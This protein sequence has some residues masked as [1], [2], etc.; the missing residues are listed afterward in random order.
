MSAGT[1]RPLAVT[2]F[3]A[4]GMADLVFINL[5]LAPRLLRGDSVRIDV[6]VGGSPLSAPPPS[7]SPT[8]SPPRAPA[9]ASLEGTGFKVAVPRGEAEPGARPLDVAGEA[10]ATALFGSGEAGLDDEA[11]AAV[12]RVIPLAASDPRAVIVIEGHADARGETEYNQRLS[13]RRA[14][15][16]ARRFTGAGVVARRLVIKAYGSRR[17][18]DSGKSAE[19]LRRNRR[20]EIVVGAG[21]GPS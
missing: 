4:L 2:T 17:P 18:A 14:Q 11:R 20:V 8:T 16:V 21:R 19:A 9:V 15:A 5:S 13:K 3:V 1:N 6:E 10:R 7:A 12:D